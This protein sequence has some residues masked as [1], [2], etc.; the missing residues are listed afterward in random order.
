MRT[1]HALVRIVLARGK[2]STPGNFNETESMSNC[3][4]HALVRI[5]LARGKSSTSENFNETESTSNCLLY[6]LYI[7]TGVI[8]PL[9]KNKKDGLS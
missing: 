8:R 7:Y 4:Y 2:S 5:V 3:T 9:I 6:I 1:Y